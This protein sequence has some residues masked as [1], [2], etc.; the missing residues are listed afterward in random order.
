MASWLGL[1]R[2][3]VNGRATSAR[4]CS[5]S[6]VD[7]AGLRDWSGQPGTAPAQFDEQPG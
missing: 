3:E 1:E 4:V 6:P 2:I 5:I 7:T